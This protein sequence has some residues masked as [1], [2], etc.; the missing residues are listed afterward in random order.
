MTQAPM[1]TWRVFNVYPDT[2]SW[3]LGE[4]EATTE[5][6]ARLAALHKWG[7]AADEPAGADSIG[8][9]DEFSVFPS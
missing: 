7:R 2:G 5:E 4:V 8:P 3:L 9:D 1:R 6:S